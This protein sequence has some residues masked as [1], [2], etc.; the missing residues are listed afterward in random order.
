MPPA[1]AMLCATFPAP[2]MARDRLLIS[3]IWTGASGE[4][5]E[6]SPQTYSSSMMSPTTA[7]RAAPSV[8]RTSA[9]LAGFIAGEGH[10]LE[11]AEDVNDSA[12]PPA[13]SCVSRA[14]LLLPE[15]GRG[16]QRHH[17]LVVAREAESLPV[18]RDRTAHDV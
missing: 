14:G 3:T 18:A 17:D 1:A 13:R 12:A 4:M 15:K 2:P 6:T 10:V 5:R 8:F 7:T 16:E 9:S 11:M